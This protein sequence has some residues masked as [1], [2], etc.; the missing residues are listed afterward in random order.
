MTSQRNVVLPIQAGPITLNVQFS[1]VEDLSPFK[2]IM[3][4]TW[5]YRMKVVSST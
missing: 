1:V 3:G 2:A 5:L 4:R